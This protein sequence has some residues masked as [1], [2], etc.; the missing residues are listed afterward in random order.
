MAGS[1][2]SPT[3]AASSIRTPSAFAGYPVAVEAADRPLLDAE[4]PPV[5]DAEVQVETYRVDM[6]R[7]MVVL[8]V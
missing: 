8:R 5:G 1:S 3:G 6:E 4:C 7:K 2:T